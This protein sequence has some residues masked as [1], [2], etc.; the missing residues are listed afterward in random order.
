MAAVRV[1]CGVHYVKDVVAGVLCAVA[2]AVIGY[3]VIPIA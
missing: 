3:C 1:C 2:F